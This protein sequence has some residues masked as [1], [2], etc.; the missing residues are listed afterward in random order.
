MYT[1][2]TRAGIT[3]V[4]LCTGEAIDHAPPK[5]LRPA[6]APW[7]ANGA[8]STRS[9][10]TRGRMDASQPNTHGKPTT[11]Q[12]VFQKVSTIAGV[13][14]ASGAVIKGDPAEVAAD[15]LPV[16]STSAGVVTE[17]GAV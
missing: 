2:A 1:I 7:H 10:R 17:T 16:P 13:I 8:G 3:S 5:R 11:R 12:G 15:G 4:V 6:H 14:A 9:L